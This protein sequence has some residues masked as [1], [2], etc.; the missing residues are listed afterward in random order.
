M[1]P[2]NSASAKFQ[3][4]GPNEKSKDSSRLSQSGFSEKADIHEGDYVHN[5]VTKLK[6]LQIKDSNRRL[7]MDL[8]VLGDRKKG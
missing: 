4:L 7:L 2:F 1:N 6:Q 3:S 5:R 8:N